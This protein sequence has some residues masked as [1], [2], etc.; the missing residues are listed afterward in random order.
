MFFTNI[1]NFE[2]FKSNEKFS[3][4]I[5]SI[6]VI[7][8]LIA[9]FLCKVFNK[10]SYQ[11]GFF[12]G[13]SS[14]MIIYL[15]KSFILSKDDKKL[16]EKYIETYDERNQLIQEKAAQI[17]IIVSVVSIGVASSV[18]SIFNMQVAITLGLTC[19]AIYLIY[20]FIAFVIRK[21]I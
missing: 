3:Q 16:K 15:V 14:V 11:L 20:L 6:I 2:E 7:T 10:N 5:I 12:I 9:A 21:K 1:K 13:L 4:I 19:V 17:A 8:T 18:I